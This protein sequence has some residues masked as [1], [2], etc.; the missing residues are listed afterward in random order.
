MP[1]T[2]PRTVHGGLSE[3]D[4]MRRTTFATMLILGIVSRSY[5]AELPEGATLLD[6]DIVWDIESNVVSERQVPS[7]AISPDD[8]S[9]AYISKGGLWNCNV[10][11]GPPTKLVDLPDTKT[12]HLASPHYRATWQQRTSAGHEIDTHVFLGTLPRDM[13][14][15][16][17]LA[18]T[19]SQDGLVYALRRTWQSN[20]ETARHDVMHVSTTGD[21]T[22]ITTI[23][24]EMSEEPHE[25][26]SFHVTRD[27]KFVVASN[28][29]T[30]LIWDVK[31]SKPIATCFDFLLPSTTSE[32]FL[33]IEIDTRQLVIADE[34]FNVIKRFD[35]V[36]RSKR[37]CDLFW[38]PDERYA[39]CRTRDELHD[40]WTGFRINLATG[41]QR[42]L[43]GPFFTEKWV[44]T[45]H[46]GEA[47]RFG[48]SHDRFEVFSDR[49]AGNYIALLPNGEAEQRMVIRVK[50]PTDRQYWRKAGRYPAIRLSADCRLFAIAIPRDADAPGYRYHLVD[51][52]G[53]KWALASS[54]QTLRVEPFRV[55]AIASQGKTIIAC[56][57]KRLFSI[58][59]K[60]VT[61]RG[62]SDDD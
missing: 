43:G 59:V 10:T 26:T 37:A 30:P 6:P 7:F 54:D 16:C 34:S 29:Y 60:M 46:A 1:F 57:D 3:G 5:S 61:S 56:D 28:G 51:Q 52:S 14:A 44:F 62:A 41:K 47:V 35:V 22:R 36:L 20:R 24:R 18:W 32:R 42:I 40:N 13:S 48:R 17:G 8:Q 55:V 12:A 9:I 23:A 15:V 21:V 49:G 45:G 4:P 39:I 38:S 50:G 31:A 58:P 19:S 33:G 2:M 53:K 27:R 11:S 25:F